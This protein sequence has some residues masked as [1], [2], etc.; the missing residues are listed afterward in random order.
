MHFDIIIVGGGMVGA[1]L[2]LALQDTSLSIALI[3]ARLPQQNDPRL[4][5]LSASSCQF[6]QNVDIWSSCAKHAQAIKQVHVSKQ[7]QF[8][9]IQLKAEDIEA[10]ALGNVVPAKYIEQALNEKL[11]QLDHVTVLRP[12]RLKKIMQ[13]EALATLV[14]DMEGTEKHLTT[15]LV[16]GADGTESTVRSQLGIATEVIDHQQS[17]IVL[18]TMLQR[19]HQHIAYERFVSE[20]AIAMLPLE[21]HDDAFQCATIWSADNKT[22]QSLMALTDDAFL[23]RLQKTFG[24]RLG[25]LKAIST[26]YCYPLRT[27]K[28]KQLIEGCVLLLG[29]AAHTLH[30]IAAQGFNLALYEVALVAEKIKEELLAQRKPSIKALEKIIAPMEKQQ[31]ISMTVS[32][33]LPHVFA[34]KGLLA[35]LRPFAMLS[36]DLAVPIKRQFINRLMGK[37]GCV[38]SLLLGRSE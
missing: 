26:R 31:G 6:L 33:R 24:Y 30:P 12:A 2:A 15:P 29:N 10:T 18:R 13:T 1:G 22:V 36:L 17:A 32:S 11:V 27:V 35:F 25:R 19:P 14:V 5:A 7:G 38:P 16:I 3:D 4:F 20:G 28:A 37:A 23:T 8:G 9:L 21:D 34:N